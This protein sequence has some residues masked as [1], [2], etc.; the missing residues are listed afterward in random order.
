MF[1]GLWDLV[2]DFIFAFC[3]VWFCVFALMFVILGDLC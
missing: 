2:F 3:V 1:L